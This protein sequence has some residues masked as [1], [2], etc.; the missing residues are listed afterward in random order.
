[1]DE[2]GGAEKVL[3]IDLEDEIVQNML[4]SHRGVVTWIPLEQRS[5]AKA[6]AP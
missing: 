3:T 1:M 2:L 6:P 4:I 5:P